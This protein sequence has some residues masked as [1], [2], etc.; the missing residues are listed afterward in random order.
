LPS[1]ISIATAV[2][3]APQL[4]GSHLLMGPPSASRAVSQGL[5]QSVNQAGICQHLLCGLAGT[6]LR[7]AVTSFATKQ[8]E[9]R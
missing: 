2:L 1:G 9:K 3:I 4:S 8:G 5:S 6:Q 7:Y